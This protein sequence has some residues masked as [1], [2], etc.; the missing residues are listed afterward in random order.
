M[1]IGIVGSGYMGRTHIDAYKNCG[2]SELYVCDTNLE[3]AQKLANEYGAT[4]FADFDDMLDKVKLDAVSICVPTPLHKM[5]AIKALNKGVAVLCEKPFA[6]SVEESNEIVEVSKK[7]GTPIMVA[8][9]LRFGK[10]YVYLKNAIKD[11]R[12]GKLLALNMERHSTMPL[13]SA[14]SWLDN[15]KK[16]GGAV[17]DL[18]VHE[19]DIAVYLLGAP[20]AVTSTGDYKQ[21][22][23]LYHYDDIAVSAQASWRAIKNFPFKCGFDANFENATVL[24]D[25]TNVTVI[26]GENIDNKVLEKENFPDYIKS[27]NFYANEICY[28]LKHLKDKDFAHSPCEESVLSIKTVYSELE[29]I[30]EKKT[31]TL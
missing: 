30:L 18:H 20:K 8:H 22:S 2:I 13:W 4:A 6:S 28:F 19:T 15:M 9:C 27:D 7:T 14:G 11:G 12:F 3:N 21:C 29:S 5:L 10:A 31:I 16:S 26:D 1:K 24:Y 25:G 17:V 23:T